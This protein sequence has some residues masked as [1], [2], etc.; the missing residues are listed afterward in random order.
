MTF[1]NTQTQPL[2]A[3]D[4]AATA[5][6]VRATLATLEDHGSD[7]AA[8]LETQRPFDNLSYA[9]FEKNEDHTMVCNLMTMLMIAEI[10][11][12]IMV[13]AE[14]AYT[15]FGTDGLLLLIEDHLG[16]L[17]ENVK[18]VLTHLV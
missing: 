17:C 7:M 9:M 18:F 13:C 12:N 8:V 10:D 6:T 5:V 15:Q 16:D 14:H 3:A 2:G 11:H 4:H 1:R